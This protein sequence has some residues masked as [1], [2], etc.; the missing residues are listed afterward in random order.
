M[1]R[2]Q[3]KEIVDKAWVMREDVLKNN[4]TD[5]RNRIKSSDEILEAAEYCANLLEAA[6][7]APLY[8]PPAAKIQV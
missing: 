1:I 2:K 8:E 5:F 4:I 6:E 3:L 7:M